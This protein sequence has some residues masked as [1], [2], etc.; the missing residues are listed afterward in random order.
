MDRSSSSLLLSWLLV[1]VGAILVESALSL[2]RQ[3]YTGLLLKNALVAEVIPGSP[4]DRAGLL[5]GD[6]IEIPAEQRGRRFQRRPLEDR[7]PA[8]AGR[9]AP[10][11]VAGA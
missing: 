6:R 11:R 8:V 7:A 9:R 5:P 3:P 10:A 2:P 1:P 4:A